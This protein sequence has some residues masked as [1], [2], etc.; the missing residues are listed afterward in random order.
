MQTT[1]KTEAKQL[2]DN[3]PDH[4]TLNDIMYELYVKQK[5][6]TGMQASRE[7]RVMTHAAMKK[8]YRG[9]VD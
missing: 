6:E 1:A 4:A 3:L 2:I 7:N 5:I 8:R 9:D